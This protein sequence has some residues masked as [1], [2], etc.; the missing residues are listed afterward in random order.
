[1]VVCDPALAAS[2]PEP[3][4]AAS[5]LNALGHAVEGPVTTL[6]NPVA[7]LAGREAARLIDVAYAGEAPDRDTLALA[8]LLAGYSIDSAW[9]GLHHVLSQT[10]VRLAEIPHG[11]ANAIMVQHTIG[12]LKRR[13]GEGDAALARRICALTGATRLSELGVTSA[14]LDEC[15]AA[16]A[17]RDELALTPPRAS[18]DELRALYDAAA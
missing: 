4:L 10:L 3:E 17:K 16:A 13:G 12:A 9:Y 5:A 1:M 11:A 15:A 8:A 14:K 6:A 2:Q 18:Y 7:T